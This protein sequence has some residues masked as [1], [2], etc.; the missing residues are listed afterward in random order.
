MIFLVKKVKRVLRG[1]VLWDILVAIVQSVRPLKQSEIVKAIMDDVRAE[2]FAM[3]H[4]I[5]VEVTFATV[6][7]QTKRLHAGLRAIIAPESY[8]KMEVDANFMVANTA[9]SRLEK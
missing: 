8:R 7:H 5:V 2:S 6:N 9:D 4:K 3:R 1:G